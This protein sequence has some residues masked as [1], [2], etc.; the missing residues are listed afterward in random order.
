MY[1]RK[2]PVAFTPLARQDFDDAL[3][4]SLI[5]WGRDR[6]SRYEGMLDR[7]VIQ[8]SEYPDIGKARPEIMPGCRSHRAGQHSV[9]YTISDDTVIVHRILHGRRDVT[10][11][12]MDPEE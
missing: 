9:Y 3:L 1:A 6:A 8:I 11:P 4:Y 12:M 7:A 10:P 2:R 5:T